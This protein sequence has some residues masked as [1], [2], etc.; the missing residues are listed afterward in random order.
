VKHSLINRIIYPDVR[1]EVIDNL[2]LFL[3]D[4]FTTETVNSVYTTKYVDDLIFGY[5]ANKV[6]VNLEKIRS[7][8]G[9]HYTNSVV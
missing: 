1:N 3:K 8:Y 2:L 9:A 7:E 5:R 6:E 4:E